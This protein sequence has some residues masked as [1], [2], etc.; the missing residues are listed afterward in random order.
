MTWCCYSVMVFHIPVF[1]GCMVKFL[2][3]CTLNVFSLKCIVLYWNNYKWPCIWTLA[4]I[5]TSSKFSDARWQLASKTKHICG[6]TSFYGAS[7]DANC[8]HAKQSLKILSPFL[9]HC[10]FVMT[11]EQYFDTLEFLFRDSLTISV[12]F[13]CG[14]LFYS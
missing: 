11:T 2:L 10:L 9:Q 5:N 13:V 7:V 8:T 3:Y 14:V 4:C 1:T 12:Q 6:A